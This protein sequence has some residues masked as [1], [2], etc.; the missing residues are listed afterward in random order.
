MFNIPIVLFIFKRDTGLE[1]IIERIKYVCPQKIYI[2]ADGPRNDNERLQCIKCRE[3]VESLIDWKCEIIKDYADVN[4]GVLNNIGF[5]ARRIFEKE[6]YAIFLE[7]DNLPEISFFYFCKE[8]LYRYRNND[9]VLW[10]CGTNYL[11]N[12]ECEYSYVFTQHLLPC[13]WASWSK[14]YL[15]YYDGYLNGIKD[16]KKNLLFKKS[17]SNK[18]LFKQQLYSVERTKYLIDTNIIKS[19]WDYQMLFSLR[20]NDLYGISPCINLI[21]NIGV[22]D[23][24]IH[25]GTTYENEMTRRFCSIKTQAISFPLKHPKE[26]FINKEYDNKVGKVLLIPVKDRILK[27]IAKILKIIL[28]MN[29]NESFKEFLKKKVGMK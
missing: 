29:K 15:R 27:K 7:D 12:F 18:P 4:R 11:E 22:D 24:S 14:K 9:K 19:S 8:L 20:A 6:E 28:R 2:V 16:E 3:L 26:I 1:K 25:G 5:G 21:E 17:Y 23:F 10:I 13:G